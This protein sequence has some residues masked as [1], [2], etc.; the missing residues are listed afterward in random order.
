MNAIT[1]ACNF[2]DAVD[3]AASGE[4]HDCL[5]GK[6]ARPSI[7]CP[8]PFAKI[9]LFT[10]TPNQIYIHRRLIPQR[11]VSRSSRTRDGMRW[12]QAAPKTRALV[13][14]RRSRV[15]L[16]PR[17]RRQVCGS[18]SADDGD[19]QARSPGRARRKPLKPLRRECRVFQ[20]DLW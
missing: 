10:I 13:C 20:A 17:R 9:F 15:V 19:K 2:R 14:G 18:N 6:S 3:A 5:T 4:P 12:T 7:S 1:F 8:V 11:G 16:T